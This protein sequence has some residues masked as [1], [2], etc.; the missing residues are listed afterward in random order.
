MPESGF[1]IVKYDN[2]SFERDP[3]PERPGRSR[4]YS[5]PGVAAP[6]PFE[7]VYQ[8]R[9]VCQAEADRLSATAGGEEI[10]I[11]LA[12]GKQYKGPRYTYVVAEV[13]R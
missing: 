10:D 1:C 12:N 11:V 2:L 7:E 6:Q 13:M 5:N 4:S 8:D 9:N 3:D